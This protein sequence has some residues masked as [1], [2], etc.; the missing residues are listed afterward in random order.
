MEARV[1][2]MTGDGA[3]FGFIPIIVAALLMIP[4]CLY[5]LDVGEVAVI[6][7]MGGSVA[8]VGECDGYHA[9]SDE[10]E[11]YGEYEP[12]HFCVPFDNANESMT[13][14]QHMKPARMLHGPA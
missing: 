2:R 3:G 8:T 4:A 7:N 12:D 1:L 6:R 10:Q 13:G 11:C 14:E 5:S 9:D